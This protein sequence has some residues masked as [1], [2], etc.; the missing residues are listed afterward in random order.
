MQ[1]DEVHRAGEGGDGVGYTQLK[2]A[3]P[4]FGLGQQA[5]VLQF[6]GLGVGHVEVPL[7]ALD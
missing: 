3:L 1:L 6:V 7:D 4:A 5:G 2:L